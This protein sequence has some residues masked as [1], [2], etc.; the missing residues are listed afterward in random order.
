MVEGFRQ[1]APS[2]ATD[3]FVLV[4]CEIGASLL[5][6]ESSI[7]LRPILTFLRAVVSV[8]CWCL[9]VG[10][11]ATPGQPIPN[12]PRHEMS[13]PELAGGGSS[14]K[15]RESYWAFKPVGNPIPPRVP[16]SDWQ[17]NPID[18][19]VLAKLVDKGINPVSPAGKPALIRRAY[20]DLAGLP[21]TPE[22]VRAFETDDS[23]DAYERV[24]DQLLA[25]PRY[26]EKWARH[27][28]DLVRFAE[29]NG[30]ERDGPK[31]S[32]WRYRDYVIDAFNMNKRYDQ[33]IREQ[34]AG[35]E[36][37]AVTAES[38]VATGYQ[39]LGIWDD[40]PVDAD[41]AYYDSLDDVVATTAQTFLGLTVNCARCHDHKIDPI[42]QTDYYR[43]LAFFHNTYNNVKQGEFKKSAFTLN[44]TET[45]ASS[46]ERADFERRKT[47]LEERIRSLEAKIA[48]FEEQI[49]AS[50]S[51]PEKDDAKDSRTRSALIAKKRASAL[52]PKALDE[53][54]AVSEQL[55]EVQK[56]ELRPLPEALVIRENGATAPETFVLVRGNAHVLGEKVVPGFPAVFGVTDPEMPVRNDSAKSSGRRRVL[57]EW[58]ASGDNLLTSRVMVNRIWQHHLG[59]GIVRSSNNFGKLGERPTHPELLDWL[60]R[61]FVDSGWDMKA[62]HKRVMLSK[63]YRMSSDA[64]ESGLRVDP[65]NDLFWR[66]DMLRLTAEEIRDSVLY[67]TGNLNQKMGGPSIYTDVPREV[68]ETASQ[69]DRAWGKSSPEEQNR[70]SI[71]VYVK[72]SLIEPVLGTFDLA[73]TDSPCAVR[74]ATTVPTQA[75]TMLN[76]RFFNDQAESFA[77]RL[78]REAGDDPKAQA[79]RAFSLALS[80]EPTASEITMAAEM[81]TKLQAELN[82]SAGQALDRFCLMVINL[83][84]F[85]YLD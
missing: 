62:M 44:T 57:A 75:L 12:D 58:I 4:C 9:A 6:S 24:I 49:V 74:F 46:S 39:R 76:N 47:E 16:D 72:R 25:S 5:R 28:L 45:I 22:E 64:S 29:T 13:A 63:T 31:P 84:E 82:L 80:R 68:L 69:P 48:P 27:W 10:A 26:G 1:S 43:L 53:Y 83:N 30:Y 59:R 55:A 34:I 33:F 40:E 70:R 15:E 67:L 36:L 41:Q 61:E 38:L 17:T 77:G 3:L 7:M 11:I 50:F 23:P 65:N 78:Q 21:P 85:A 19:Y 37:D 18:A 8:G 71:Y 81:I 42:P 32:A 52:E 2:G 56:S 79:V 54:L 60:A 51:N 14:F 73:D 35:D 20:Y 66:F